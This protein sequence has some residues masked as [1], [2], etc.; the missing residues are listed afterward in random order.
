MH[1]AVPAAGQASIPG[2]V[3][4]AISWRALGLAVATLLPA[5]FWTSMLVLAGNIFGYEFS[6][7]V[8]MT[9]AAAITLFLAI[10]V[11]ALPSGD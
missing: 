10:I 7:L 3:S 11:S 1:K 4:F 2:A 9:V 5:L 8:L 6:G